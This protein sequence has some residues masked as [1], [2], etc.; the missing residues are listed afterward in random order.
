MDSE[1]NEVTWTRWALRSPDLARAMDG[2]L[3]GVQKNT[4]FTGWRFNWQGVEFVHEDIRI[5]SQILENWVWETVPY[6]DDHTP[7]GIR[8]RPPEAT[9]GWMF[10]SF[11]PAGTQPEEEIIYR[12]PTSETEAGAYYTVFDS[13]AAWIKTHTR[14][15]QDT[16]PFYGQP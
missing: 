16:V 2:I 13:D 1:R 5:S 14:A 8:C 9:E 7:C 4:H 10:L 11:W 3:E 15:I 12:G 6:T